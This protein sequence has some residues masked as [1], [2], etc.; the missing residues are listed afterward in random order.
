MHRQQTPFS[1]VTPYEPSGD[2]PL[3]IKY[4]VQ[5]VKD[6]KKSQVL[7]GVTGSGKTFTMANIIAQ[8]NKPTLILAHNKT[9]VA[10]LYEE[11]KTFFPNN[12]VEYFVSYYD[13]YQPEAY[14]PSSDT[15]I[16]KDS[17]INETI[18][19]MRHRA[20]T[21]LLSRNDVIIVASVSCIYGIGSTESY[22]NM[23]VYLEVNQK[24]RRDS[25][26]RSLVESQYQRNEFDFSRGTFRSKGDVVEVFLP[27]EEYS[28]L[29]IEI[30]GDEIEKLS[31]IDPLSNK[32]IKII[33]SMT[34]FPASHYATT[35]DRLE[36]AIKSIK[37]ELN[38]ELIKL[39]QQDRILHM[40]RLEQRTLFDLEMLE[41]MCS[42]PNLL[43]Q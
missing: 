14:V 17:Q 23:T 41:V 12:A 35:K 16:E 21:S 19:R 27:Q 31:I 2:Q 36:K 30:F 37:E 32:T 11:I 1:L 33:T 8:V 25:L 4:L 38:T 5:G 18:D 7:L 28:A 29:R 15:F 9:L 20:T 43:L 24:L 22:Q 6:N 3:A 26:L 13:Y 39:K 42:S 40:Q 10:Q 34:I